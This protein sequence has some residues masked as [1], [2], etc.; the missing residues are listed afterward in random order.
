MRRVLAAAVLVALVLSG[1]GGDDDTTETASGS[2]STT[3][4]PA[5]SSSSEPCAAPTGE[6]VDLEAKPEVE[7]PDAPVDELGCQDLVVGDGDEVTTGSDVVTVH[8]VG[9]AQ[10]SGKEFDSSWGGDP[11]TFPLDQVIRGWTQGIPGM[12]VG[13]RRV[14]TIPGDLAYGPSGQP[15]AGIGPDDTLV[16]V[17]D[18]LAVEAADAA[19]ASVPAEFGAAPCAPATKPDVRPDSFDDSPMDCLAEGV[20][21]SA[22][23]TT[24]EGTFTIH[25]RPDLAP[26]A[27]NSFVQLARWGWFDGNAFHRVVPGF[28][29]QTGDPVGD[30]PGSGGPGYTF[31]DELPESVDDYVPGTVA[32]ANAG[33][34]TN[35]SQWFTCIDCSVLPSPDYS[36]FGEVVEGMD[37][38][39]AINDLGQPDQTPS[40]PVS[41]TTIEIVEG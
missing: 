9:V 17:I 18:L 24:T 23:V 30:P 11:V 7:V 36:I 15:D 2:D 26:V 39:Q 25:L 12:K 1:C 29:N 13:G 3:S 14:L 28:V 22:T 31:G 19:P 16:F 10:S 6:D 20:D 38:V 40:K 21:Y 8:Y 35:G 37:V 27:V 5:A 41:I 34:G 4:T 32:M 33:P